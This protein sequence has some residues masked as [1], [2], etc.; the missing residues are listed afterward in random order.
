MQTL[1]TGEVADETGV[2][3]HTVRYYEEKGLLPHVPRSAAGHR[4]FT[5]EHIA[6]IRFVKRAQELGFT[7]E[8]I[9]ELLSLRASPGAGEEVREKTE[10]KIEEIEAKVRDL[11]RIQSKLEELEAACEKHGGADDCLVLHALE[12]PEEAL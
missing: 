7:L 11:R 1:T 8:E 3:I 4:Q 9:K 2:S 6:H 10:A 12:D 5:G